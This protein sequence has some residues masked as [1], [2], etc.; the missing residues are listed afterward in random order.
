MND[1]FKKAQESTMAVN[2]SSEIDSI[3][4]T[5]YDACDR[6][7]I[8]MLNY[9][10]EEDKKAFREKWQRK[11]PDKPIDEELLLYIGIRGKIGDFYEW[12]EDFFYP[13]K[14]GGDAAVNR[15]LKELEASRARVIVK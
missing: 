3:I 1:G 6:G 10:A 4:K 7:D 9:R 8:E 15:L 11:F 12:Y 13:L 5:F 2:Y 14:A